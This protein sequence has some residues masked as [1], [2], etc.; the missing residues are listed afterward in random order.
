MSQIQKAN[1]E[2]EFT[3]L[4]RAADRPDWLNRMDREFAASGQVRMEDLRRLL[5]DPNR[6]VTSHPDA[7]VSAFVA[8]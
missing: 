7:S 6:R 3:K 4:M 2:A 8:E 5:G 1:I